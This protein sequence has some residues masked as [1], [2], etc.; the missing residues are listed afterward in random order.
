MLKGLSNREYLVCFCGCA[1]QTC[2]ITL[3][4]RSLRP[5]GSGLITQQSINVKDDIEFMLASWPS[6][7]MYHVCVCMYC[8]FSYCKNA[9]EPCWR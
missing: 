7:S 3:G 6:E 2:S 1:A 4:V 8:V 5:H 9:G